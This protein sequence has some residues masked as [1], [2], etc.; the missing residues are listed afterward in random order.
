VELEAS[1]T[2]R[3]GAA[4]GCSRVISGGAMPWLR[5][6][7]GRP[8]RVGGRSKTEPVTRVRWRGRTRR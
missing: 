6:T 1:L 8:V 7:G 2:G 4:C 3:L 5:R